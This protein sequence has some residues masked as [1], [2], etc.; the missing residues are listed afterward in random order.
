MAQ[1]TGNAG[2]AQST[3]FNVV[4]EATREAVDTQRAAQDR[5]L[6][7][8]DLGNVAAQGQLG[9]A[10]GNARSLGRGMIGAG[11]RGM[12]FLQDFISSS[13]LDP[14][15]K[16]LLDVADERNQ[17]ML[18]AQGLEGP[19]GPGMELRNETQNQL[20][21]NA[22]GQKLGA[23]QFLS[24]LG[25]QATGREQD[26]TERFGGNQANFL[27]QLAS[28]RANTIS[29]VQSNVSSLQAGKVG[30]LV[31]AVAAGS[32]ARAGGLQGLLGGAGKIAGAAS[33]AGG[34]KKLLG[35]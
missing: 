33:G 16:R 21:S 35:I 6:Q 34:F 5:I 8:L 18:S 28:D 23:A 12:G 22:F 27:S 15:T 11:E 29:G 2:S 14:Q 32:R 9:Q 10:F 25:A 13:G 24:G 4:N 20:L 31:G 19:G 30:P 7:E 1:L 26:L 17:R 3:S